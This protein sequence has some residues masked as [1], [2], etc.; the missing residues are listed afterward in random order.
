MDLSTIGQSSVLEAAVA[1]V[2]TP[3]A[4]VR[5]G[6]LG[7]V[8]VGLAPIAGWMWLRV[9]TGHSALP[10]FPSIPPEYRDY[11]PAM[12]LIVIL[13]MSV[14]LP[15]VMGGR[16]PHVLYRPGELDVSLDDVKG[17]GVVVDEAIKTLNMFLAHRTFH[18]RMGGTPRKAV[19]FEGPPGTGKTYLAKALARGAGGA[20]LF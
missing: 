11:V 17:A 20:F 9:L 8:A 19:L 16:S 2:A 7:R 14:L 4:R 3:G 18:D 1:D 10:G 6:R 12:V 15:L 5:R 13:G